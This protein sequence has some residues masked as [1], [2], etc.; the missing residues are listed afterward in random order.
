MQI[1]KHVD[2][3]CAF[4]SMPFFQDIS[5]PDQKLLLT[6]AEHRRIRFRFTMMMGGQV[7]PDLICCVI[8]RT[9]RL[10][11]PPIIGWSMEKIQVAVSQGDD[12]DDDMIPH[13]L[14]VCWSSCLVA[15]VH[16]DCTVMARS[17]SDPP[18]L[19]ELN[20]CRFFLYIKNKSKEKVMRRHL[21]IFWCYSCRSIM[22][23]DTHTGE[24]TSR[25]EKKKEK[26]R[27]WSACSLAQLGIELRTLSQRRGHAA[28]PEEASTGTAGRQWRSGGRAAGSMPGHERTQRVRVS[29]GDGWARGF[30]GGRERHGRRRPR[31][32][33]AFSCHS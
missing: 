6:C 12:S 16:P 1:A 21:Q 33:W 10:Q 7:A 22:A 23:K 11:E 32:A 20:P 9:V 5:G 28:V 14:L 24:E 19:S 25:G 31:L 29:G 2:V 18:Y 8:F 27:K 3:W 30:D 17:A 15:N 4:H 26:V 13:I